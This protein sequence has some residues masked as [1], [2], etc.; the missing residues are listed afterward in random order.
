MSYYG[1]ISEMEAQKMDDPKNKAV[2]L[3]DHGDVALGF[4][5][6]HEAVSFTKEEERRV[7]H[8][9]DCVLMP[10]VKFQIRSHTSCPSH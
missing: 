4:L 1:T 6:N 8:K 9:I 2:A 7:I 10:L 3:Q 5:E